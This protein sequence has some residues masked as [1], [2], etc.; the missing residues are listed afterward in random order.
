MKIFI[1]FLGLLVINVSY[2]SFQGDME[3]FVREQAFL[4]VTA[5]ECAAGAA[6]LVEEREYGLGRV[7]FQ[8]E[9]GQRYAENYL[10]YVKDKSKLEG[11]LVC[12]LTF[13]DDQTGYENSQNPIPAV[14]AAVILKTEDIFKLPFITLTEIQ[15]S[16]RY[17]LE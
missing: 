10:T 13:E 9:E 17:E 6:L 14:T 15:R 11:D 7:V 2:L 16:A 1:V 12:L 3:R 4:K 8:Y 5:E